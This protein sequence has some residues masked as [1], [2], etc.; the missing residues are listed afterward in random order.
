MV[1]TAAIAV[2]FLVSVE[3][4]DKSFCCLFRKE[5]G[6]ERFVPASLAESMKKKEL[7]KLLSH[8]LKLNAS[9]VTSSKTEDGG[10]AEEAG[11]GSAKKSAP[12]QMT[13]LQAKLHYLRII[14]EL[15]SY[16]AKCFSTNV[17]VSAIGIHCLLEYPL[18]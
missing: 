18:K 13:A 17:S 7:R 15:P 16:G 8:F 14:A 9:A 1:A 6:I 10:A 5:S 11:G 4:N 2:V 3:Q 12:T